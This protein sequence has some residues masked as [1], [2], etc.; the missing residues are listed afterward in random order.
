MKFKKEI[1]DMW[2]KEVYD[3][4]ESIDP[5]SELHWESLAIGWALAKGMSPDKSIDFGRYYT[6]FD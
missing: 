6:T 1:V 3:K 5:D 2:K 4:V